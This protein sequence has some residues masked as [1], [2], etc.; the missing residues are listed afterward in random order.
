MNEFP[1]PTFDS[2]T[3]VMAS[4]FPGGTGVML[5]GVTNALA[6]ADVDPRRCGQP[7]RG[8]Q[9]RRRPP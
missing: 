1:E 5:I 8:G 9:R 4:P 6:A 3:S 2:T 7:H